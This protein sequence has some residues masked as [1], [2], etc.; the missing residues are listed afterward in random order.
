MSIA[1]FFANDQYIIDQKVTIIKMSNSYR[2]FNPGGDQIGAIE[3]VMSGGQKV[4]GALVGKKMLP[5]TLNIQDTD[6]TTLASV[7]RGATM[8]RSNITITDGQDDVIGLL[9]QQWSFMKPK[10]TIAT[11]DDVEVATITGDWK[12][13]NF[14][15]IGVDGRQLGTI[16]KKWTGAMK[17]I[18]TSA[19][20][21][22]VTIDPAVAEDAVK[23]CLVATAISI[24]MVL[25]ESK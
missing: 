18:F 8:M 6:G 1:A 22:L 9:H 11:P 3:Q 7:T 14:Q 2:V 15:I 20:K 23:V 13:W 12:G 17:E 19:D 4:L 16:N 5:F 25:K 24:D 10:F 21:Y